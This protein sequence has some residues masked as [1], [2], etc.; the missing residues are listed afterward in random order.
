MK[1]N[2]VEIKPI[3]MTPLKVQKLEYSGTVY[4]LRLTQSFKD[5]SLEIIVENDD[6]CKELRYT[7]ATLLQ[8]E[9][10]FFYGTPIFEALLPE[11]RNDIQLGK[12]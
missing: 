11:I 2:K 6:T 9:R 10:I 7:Y 1:T 8:N 5:G 4:T 12:I 3:I